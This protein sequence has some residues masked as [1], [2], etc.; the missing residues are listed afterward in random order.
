MKVNPVAIPC[1]L[2]VPPA[3]MAPPVALIAKQPDLGTAVLV[4]AAGFFVIFFAGLPWKWLAVMVCAGLAMLPVAWH[5]MHD[6]QRNRIMTLID[7]TQ[8]P[9]GKDWDEIIRLKENGTI[10]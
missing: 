1:A 9:L 7:P 3:L 8:D 4:L 2:V 10:D 6:Y 5:F